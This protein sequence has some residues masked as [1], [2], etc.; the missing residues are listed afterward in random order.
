M[1]CL[2]GAQQF[3]GGWVWGGLVLRRGQGLHTCSRKS[4]KNGVAGAEPSLGVD[5]DDNDS[6]ADRRGVT[7]TQVRETSLGWGSNTASASLGTGARW[8][9]KSSKAA[10]GV[11]SRI[12][13]KK[14]S[15]FSH[16]FWKYCTS[17][18]KSKVHLRVTH[19]HTHTR[20]HTPF[21]PES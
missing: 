8:A 17:M 15:Y 10:R 16:Y 7:Q 13:K 9:R 5:P 2:E 1:T 18:L 14:R 19:T 4:H 21:I 6:A 12:M 11:L 3:H 20:S